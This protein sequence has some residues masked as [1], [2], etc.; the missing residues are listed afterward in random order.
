MPGRSGR[1][2]KQFGAP[3]GYQPPSHA[4]DRPKVGPADPDTVR[5]NLRAALNPP[6]SSTP[7]QPATSTPATPATPPADNPTRDLSVTGAI[8]KI[9]AY[10]GQ[11]NKAI[12]DA[13]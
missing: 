5:R 10:P 4:I 1:D 7:S 6:R 11:I 13:S 8:D 3:V 9:R 2:E 12:D